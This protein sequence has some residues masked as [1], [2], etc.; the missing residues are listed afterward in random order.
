MSEVSSRHI[1]I[2]ISREYGAG[3]RSVAK[4]LSGRLGLPWY[5]RD[6]VKK[7]AA[8]SGYTEEE[9]NSE[10]EA[11]KSGTRWLTNLISPVAYESST[12]AIF[13]AQKE[14]ILGMT[15]KES[16]IIIGRCAN[17]ILKEAGIPHLSVFLYADHEH[18][19]KRAAELAE[20]GDM[21]LEK[22]IAR[23]DS[24]RAAYYKIYTGHSFGDYHDYH[25]SLDTGKIGYK[26]C[27]DIITN[28]LG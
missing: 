9:I 13:R 7:T 26:G 27:V 23:R 18:R 25:I 14:V 22:F 17:L 1:I 10:G 21:D 28:I 11:V 16:C 5:D 2:T 4:E 15:K 24:R 8:L 12:D 20:N 3:G 6:F 19:M